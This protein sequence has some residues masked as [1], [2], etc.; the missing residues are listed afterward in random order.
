MKHTICRA[1]AV[2]CFTVKYF[3]SIATEEKIPYRDQNA[4]EDL[5]SPL[6]TAEA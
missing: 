6:G 2:L 3:I 1:N 4:A 5:N